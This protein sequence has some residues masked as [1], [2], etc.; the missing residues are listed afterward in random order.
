MGT[1]GWSAQ[2]LMR[3]PQFPF[4]QVAEW[5]HEGTVVPFLGAGA[6]RVGVPAEYQLPDGPGLARELIERMGGAF[7]GTSSADLPKIA[8]FYEHLVFD[9]PALYAYLHDRFQAGQE[10]APLSRAARLLAAVP[11]RDKPMFIITTNYD[12]FIERAFRE[13]Q[14][15]FCVITQNMRD[16]EY[17]PSRISATLPN[18]EVLMTDGK[19]FRWE[20]AGFPAGAAYLFKMHGSVHRVKFDGMDDLI[21]TEDDYVDFLVNSGGALSPFFPPASLLRAYKERRFLFLGYSLQ[22]WNFRA[23]LRL[24]AKRNAISAGER[25]HWAIQR[26]PDE[27]DGELWRQRNVNVYDGDLIEFCDTLESVWVREGTN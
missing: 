20:D 6:S 25:R 8:Q 15:P 24:L 10:N 13:A 2:V 17:G 3:L 27:L 23:F 11:N 7:P 19:E 1:K 21:V 12:S 9:R 26:N 4:V 16:P 14:R 22:D 18:G 5:L